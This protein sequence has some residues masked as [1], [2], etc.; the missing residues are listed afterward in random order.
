MTP[1]QIEAIY[2]RALLARRT[3]KLLL[4]QQE[5]QEINVS[6]SH[7]GVWSTQGQS[8]SIDTNT[9]DGARQGI[10]FNVPSGIVLGS[11]A[12]TNTGTPIMN[13]VNSVPQ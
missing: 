12:I 11:N 13:Q 10:R 2:Q 1:E 9:I 7:V 5:Y 3:E 8:G 4:A 6:R